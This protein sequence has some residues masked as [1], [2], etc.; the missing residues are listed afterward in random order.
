MLRLLP[1]LLFATAAIGANFVDHGRD[2]KDLPKVPEGFEATLYAKEPLVRNPCSMAFDTQGRMFVGMGPQYRNPKPDTPRDSIVIVYDDDHDGIADRTKV[3]ATGFNC[4]QGMAW[5]G[6]DLWVANSPDLTIVRDLDGDDVADEYVKVFTDL[7]NIEHALHGLVWAPD[8]RLYMSKGNS[9]GISLTGT[10]PKETGRLAPRAF[11]ELW[12]M[13]GPDMDAPAPVTFKPREYHNTY[14]DPRDDWGQMGGILRCEDMGRHLEIVARGFRN[15]WDIGFDSGFN[16]LCTDN[17][18]TEGDR[19][20]MPFMG[21]HF[22][23]GHAWSESWSG[24]NHPP[25]APMSGPVFQGSGTGIVFATSPVFP[26]EFRGVWFIND[27][28]RKTTFVYRSQWQGAVI[29]PQG[30]AWQEFISGKEALY[31]PTDLEFGADGAL[32]V[33]GWGREYGGTFDDKGGQTNEGR[34]FRIAPRGMKPLATGPA[35]PLAERTFDQLVADFSSTVVARRVDAADELAR[36]GAKV[37]EPLMQLLGRTDLDPAVQ[38]W[39]LWTLSRAVPDS[40]ELDAWFAAKAGTKSGPD[41]RVQAL[42]ILAERHRPLPEV[43]TQCISDSEPRI[44][45]EAVQAARATRQASFTTALVDRAAEEQERLTRYALWQALRDLL[46]QPEL[47]K[48]LADERPGVRQTALLALLDLGALHKGDVQP[49]ANDK[50]A[51]VRHVAELFLNPPGSGTLTAAVTGARAFALAQDIKVHG[52][53][54][55]QPGIFSVGSPC[56][57]DR[58]YVLKQVPALLADAC[59]IMTANNDDHSS[60]DNLV[61]FNLPVPSTVYIAHDVRLR[62]RPAWMHDYADT[63]MTAITEDATFHLWS[64]AYPAGQVTLGGNSDDASKGKRSQYFVI[65]KAQP[66]AS[67]GKVT[68]IEAALAAK[69]DAR[70]GEGLFFAQAGC[71]S[72]HRVGGRG[73]NFGPEL[74]NLSE[75]VERQFIAQSI[76]DPS[77]V[78]TEGFAAHMVEAQGKSYLGILLEDGAKTLKLGLADGSTQVVTKKTMARHEVL[79]ASPMPPFAAMLDPQQ[80]ADLIAFLSLH[81]DAP[82]E[83]PVKAQ[84]KKKAAQGS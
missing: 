61:T 7:G 37:Q 15:P 45:F 8:G 73:T 36:R 56:Y 12:G 10:E 24:V 81:V 33:L 49:F 54:G 31:R 17:D 42:R 79:P 41:A 20:L 60:G 57:I 70:H 59:M 5:H 43:V 67:P 52:K 44:R 38:T 23:W 32:Y 34:I 66:L 26:K 21:A 55:C 83:P 51:G 6:R 58:K 30:G 28:L 16:W 1:A 71:A 19:I 13:P 63:D 72:C 80:V 3:F 25:T 46:P 11:R 39:A 74:T 62:E 4:I 65:L 77:A 47:R 27:W 84:K 48:L 18:Q 14:Q 2:L 69:G 78:I 50:D 22:G 40:S 53:G 75:R 64:K 35:Q 76:L 29:Q 68:T 9:K 82:G